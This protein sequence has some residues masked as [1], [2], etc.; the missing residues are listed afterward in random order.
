MEKLKTYLLFAG[1]L[2]LVF[3]MDRNWAFAQEAA[4]RFEIGPEDSA[5]DPQVLPKPEAVAVAAIRGDG[6]ALSWD[7]RLLIK[8]RVPGVC[9]DQQ[10][11]DDQ[12]HPNGWWVSLFRPEALAD[13]ESPQAIGQNEN[14]FSPWT[15]LESIDEG[16]A[17]GFRYQNALAILPD[18][19]H[20]GENPY[21]SDAAGNE[22][23]G[24]EY[25]TYRVLVTTQNYHQANTFAAD[26][27][28]TE[29]NNTLPNCP[30]GVTDVPSGKCE[31]RLG[32]RIARIVVES[33]RTDQAAVHLAEF[34]FEDA[35]DC[36][37]SGAPPGCFHE[38][39]T[40]TGHR[41]RG[42]EPTLTFDG[43]LMIWQGHPR[44]TGWIGQLVYSFNPEP[45]AL[46]GWSEPRSILAM[47]EAE[48][49]TVLGGIPFHERYPI[50]KEPLRRVDG[51]DFSETDMYPAGYPWISLD[52]T[53]LF[54][55]TH[56]VASDPD[57][58]LRGG[59][60]VIGRW[61]GYQVRHIDGPLNPDRDT[62]LRLF[63]SSP[64]AVP[65][66]WAPYR[67]APGVPIPHVRGRPVYPLFGSK[68]GNYGEVSFADHEDGD[69]V[70][71]LNMN[72]MLVLAHDGSNQYWEF[73]PSRTPDTSGRG[74]AATLRGARFPEDICLEDLCPLGF[75]PKEICPAVCPAGMVT[76]EDSEK[77]CSE[78]CG[79]AKRRCSSTHDG[80]GAGQAIHFR[81][82][83]FLEVPS[84]GF[85]HEIREALTVELWVYREPDVFQELQLA[86]LP[87][88]WEFA[89]G[90]DG[91]LRVTVQTEST[92]I[93]FEKA[94]AEI[95][96]E[97]WT[98]VAFSY[99]GSS[100]ML[101][102]YRDGNLLDRVVAMGPA[103]PI[104]P[105][106]CHWMYVGPKDAGPSLGVQI[107]LD[108][109][110]L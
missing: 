44:N 55:T 48:K 6:Y 8:T 22:A 13:A 103:S 89:L 4:I 43:R 58:A 10:G 12:H 106:T 26:Y 2:S 81:G 19:S 72:E 41:L 50:A 37:G 15:P 29:F 67:D 31:D 108:D 3:L 104:Q 30:D 40:E 66:M 1:F 85:Q 100:N 91:E 83:D 90:A 61:T 92:N 71:A 97:V 28:T 60:A 47:H 34:A 68:V 80:A 23:T 110:K 51:S 21:R 20:E 99:D 77:V 79:E 96:L 75:C 88:A 32:R 62:T 109:F 87:D 74:A 25:E 24:G 76:C 98:H 95:P 102:L 56:R 63:F 7:G 49:D 5:Q 65:G 82:Q 39:R 27:G 105:S 14:A 64:G 52:G 35:A 69:Y 53:E 57:Q 59:L 78:I 38:L 45:G 42:I 16:R 86:H 93:R 101:S 36:L 54:H 17:I 33:P 107:R 94:E 70:T 18:P 84:L 9:D 11:C 73:D 46:T